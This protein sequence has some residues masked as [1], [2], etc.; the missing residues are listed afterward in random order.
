MDCYGPYTAKDGQCKFNGTVT[1]QC[2]SGSGV[3]RAYQAKNA[4]AVGKTVSTLLQ[5]YVF[6]VHSRKVLHYLQMRTSQY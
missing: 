4:Y 3:P 5:N 6:I 2:P 1:S